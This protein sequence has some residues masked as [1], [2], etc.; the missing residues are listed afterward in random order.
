MTE[1]K[2]NLISLP[3]KPVWYSINDRNHFTHDG[4]ISSYNYPRP[5]P[6]FGKP[7][8]TDLGEML[9]P[10]TT[11]EITL[12]DTTK[13]TDYHCQ[14]ISAI[15]ESHCLYQHGDKV[16]ALTLGDMA[17]YW[18]VALKPIK[19]LLKEANSSGSLI[20]FGPVWPALEKR[21]LKHRKI[22]DKS[23]N[24]FFYLEQFCERRKDQRIAEGIYAAVPSGFPTKWGTGVHVSTLDS[25]LLAYYPT[26][27][28]ILD[29]KPQQ[30]KPGRY[31][32]KYFSDDYTDDQVRLLSALITGE[33]VLRYYSKAADMISVYRKLETTGIVDSCMSHGSN[34]WCELGGTHPLEVYDN[35]DVEL[36]VM[37]IG[38]NTEQ[39]YARA[40]YN[41][42]NKQYPMI[43]GQWEKM[44]VLLDREGFE[45]GVL[46][47]AVI[48]RIDV[49]NGVLMPYIDD[50]RELDR[51][52]VRATSV[53]IYSG[54]CIISEYGEYEANRYTQGFIDVDG[55][56]NT[57]ICDCCG[58]RYCNA[59]QNWIEQQEINVCDD[60]LSKYGVEI[61]CVRSRDDFTVLEGYAKRMYLCIEGEFYYDSDAAKFRGDWVHSDHTDE[62]HQI[63]DCTFLDSLDDW[64]PDDNLPDVAIK[65]DD[66]IW[67][68]FEE[69]DLN[70]TWFDVVSHAFFSK[71]NDDDCYLLSTIKALL[72]AKPQAFPMGLWKLLPEPEMHPDQ[73]D[74]FSSEAA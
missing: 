32:K 62:Y 65:T 31:I 49:S 38:D 54:H 14:A 2:Y 66:D 22:Y 8:T 43:Y 28:H 67:I 57:F 59:D 24:A 23:Q 5:R 11:P 35:S 68:T 9:F 60:C 70:N 69:F 55:N 42:K 37:Y 48:N 52:S 17:N 34:H 33:Y 39:P 56:E 26:D 44:K 47:G 61:A 50:K 64:I 30:I 12:V 21:M 6:T 41:K 40:L 63:D 15:T 10:L 53:D 4:Y 74:L 7:I 16:V 58:E 71:K 19:R 45:H 51:S 29:D 72:P 27:R 13:L 18:G 73:M 25:K 46:D 36:A 1:L 20:Y 3:G